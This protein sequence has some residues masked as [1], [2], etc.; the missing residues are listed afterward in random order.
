MN[1]PKVKQ[2]IRLVM[3]KESSPIELAICE[4]IPV[5]LKEST[6]TAQMLKPT[7]DAPTKMNVALFL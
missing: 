6:I 3:A 2:I 7:M 5:A 1:A 4:L